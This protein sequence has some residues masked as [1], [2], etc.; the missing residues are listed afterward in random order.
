MAVHL[1]DIRLNNG[2]IT[3]RHVKSAMA[4]QLLQGIRI[5]AI[6]QVLDRTGVTEAMDRDVR[7][8]GTGANGLQQ[9]QEAMTTEGASILQQEEWFFWRRIRTCGQ[10]P[11]ECLVRADR[12]R[13]VPFL[14][15]LPHD[16]DAL[17]PF[18]HIAQTDLAE[19]VI[20]DTGIDHE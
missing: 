8:T 1:V 13:H 15:A 18:I 14:G 3:A 16:V 19:L 4:Q 20:A 9:I 7:H 12:E 5:A 17:V 10:V 2:E 6:A 11:P